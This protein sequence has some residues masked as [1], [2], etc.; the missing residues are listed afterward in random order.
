MEDYDITEE[1]V[2][3]ALQRKYMSGE[4]TDEDEVYV[5]GNKK[6]IYVRTPIYRSDKLQDF[7]FLLDA[8]TPKR[9]RKYERVRTS[10]RVIEIPQGTPE[11][12]LQPDAQAINDRDENLYNNPNNSFTLR[13]Y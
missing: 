4:E 8:V 13:N 3:E 10:E 11:W 12:M 6:N 7:F 9:A 1:D 2:A 5:E